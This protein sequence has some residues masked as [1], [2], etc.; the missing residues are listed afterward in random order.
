MEKGN[1]TATRELVLLG[2]PGSS[3]HPHVLA[4]LFLCMYLVAVLGNTL[5]VLAV[6]SDS[7]LHSPMYLLLGHLAFVDVCFVSTTVPK[8][9]VNLLTGTSTIALAG[10]LAQLF[11]FISFVNMDS[12]LLCAMAYDRYVAICHPLRYA[13]LVSPRFCLRLVAGL[14]ALAGLHALLH[15]LL[16]ARLSFCASNVIRHFFCDLHPLLQLSCSDVSL[17]VLVILSVGAPL[18]LTPLAGI[19]TSY[20]LILCT[21][22][23]L[24]S[25]RGKQ[26]AFS[27]CSGHLSLVVLFYSSATA[28]YF[29]PASP[30]TPEGDALSAAVYAVVTPMLNPFLYSLRNREV[31][32][33][34]QKVLCEPLS[35]AT[36]TQDG[37]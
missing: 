24:T 7:R 5:M 12:L 26:R 10:C 6:R 37:R 3:A 20:G 32:V 13:A 30:H 17:N 15:T 23:K 8:M 28:V 1:L 4:T 35:A 16:M 36:A 11:F 22:L 25:A 9:A 2:L 19:L 18:A 31:K 14:W 21:V 34:L 27:T 33:A 29:S